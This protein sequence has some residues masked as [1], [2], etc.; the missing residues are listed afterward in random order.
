MLEFSQDFTTEEHGLCTFHFSRLY[1]TNN[2]VYYV[3]TRNGDVG[4]HAFTMAPNFSGGWRIINAPKVPDWIESLEQ[5][6]SAALLS[7]DSETQLN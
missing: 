5:T 7:V 2:F 6:L 3:T 4:G 1:T